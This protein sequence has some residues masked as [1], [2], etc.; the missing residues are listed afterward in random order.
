MIHVHIQSIQHFST[1]GLAEMMNQVVYLWELQAGPFH[2]V[3][4]THS[5]LG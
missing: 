2:M 5:I 1:V 3:S 4:S